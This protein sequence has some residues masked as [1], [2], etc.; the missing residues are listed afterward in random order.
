MEELVQV[1]AEV[2]RALKRHAFAVLA[3]REE[4]FSHWLRKQMEILLQQDKPSI[5]DRT[6]LEAD[7][8][9]WL[10][11]GRRSHGNNS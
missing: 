7:I 6:G 10:E 9:A 1:K 3:L 2:P 11:E 4:R 8:D 5:T